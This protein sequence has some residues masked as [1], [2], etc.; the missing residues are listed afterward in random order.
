METAGIIRAILGLYIGIIEKLTESSRT[1][2]RI[3]HLAGSF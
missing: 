3:H 2:P 1:P